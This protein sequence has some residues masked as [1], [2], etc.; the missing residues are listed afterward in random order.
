[1]STRLMRDSTQIFTLRN[2]G[3]PGSTF[4]SGSGQ[5]EL[6]GVVTM[7]YLDSPA[8]TS[9]ITYKTQAATNSTASNQ[10]VGFQSENVQQSSIIMME[11]G[12]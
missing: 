3:N 1:M 5:T 7:A 6:R 2:N 12:A 8:T 11:I 9:A 10:N 4:S